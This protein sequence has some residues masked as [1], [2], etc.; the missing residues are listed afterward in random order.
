MKKK[1]REVK[2]GN[3]TIGGDNPL[4]LIA[5]PCVIESEESLMEHAL[6]IKE[7]AGKA[8]V[9]F[10][11][12]ASYD[13]ANRSSLGS[14]RGPGIEK[15]LKMLASVKEKLGIPVLSD[16]HSVEEVDIAAEVLDALQIPAFLCRQTDLLVKAAK[17]GKAVNVKKGQFMSPKEMSN[18]VRKIEQSGNRNIILTER[19]TTFGY[20]MLINDFRAI[21]IMKDTGCPVVYDATH[22]VQM[23]G[24]QGSASGGEAEYVR[25]LSRA[26][27]AVGCDALF[28]EVHKTPSKAM[29]DGP[30]MLKLDDLERYL[31]EMVSIEK[32]VK[33]S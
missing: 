30:N 20:N 10:I 26:A 31:E 4:V 16:V 6:R 1:S 8:G 18:V 12:K 22:S 17:T 15:G 2:V 28:V 23:P 14:F 29:S 33:L 27:V 19:G 9:P 11:F 7:I 25:P 3:V 13:K 24:G 32:A 21:P 5:G